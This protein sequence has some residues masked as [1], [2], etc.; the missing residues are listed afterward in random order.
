MD[1]GEIAIV[2]SIW[3]GVIAILIT[4]FMLIRQSNNETRVELR[5]FRVEMRAEMRDIR[6]E[7]H[8]QTERLGQ[9]IGESE[10]KQAR[11]DAL[12][13]VLMQQSHT[14]EAAAD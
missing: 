6:S 14:H 5:E 7:I 4:L 3:G 1:I 2:V 11:L 8:A 9:R 10:L 12:N 13:E